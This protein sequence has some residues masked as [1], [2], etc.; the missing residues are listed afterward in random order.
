MSNIVISGANQG[1]GYYMAVQ[2]LKDKH[3][4]AVLDLE[5]NNLQALKETYSDNLLLYQCDLKNTNMVMSCMSD[6]A[7]NTRTIDI[8]I[9]NA[10]VCTFSS[11]LDTNESI[12][13]DVLDVNYFGA[14]RLSKAA[15]PFMKNQKSGR[16]IFTSSGVGVTG[17]LNIS[18]YSSSKG[19]IESLAKCLSIEHMNDNISFHIFQPPLTSTK[20]SAP[21]PVPT[22][23]MAKPEVVGR[24]LAKHVFS[25]KFIICSS[26]WQYVQTKLCY[27]FPIKIGHLMSQKIIQSGSKTV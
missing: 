26:F 22:E 20:S 23:F 3:T 24:Q 13:R 15:I 12:Y 4:V 19:A 21:L 25:N 17:F 6:I 9:H 8:V 1:I 18:P 2:F 11:A 5:I 16:I 14:L 10:C 7:K 27:L